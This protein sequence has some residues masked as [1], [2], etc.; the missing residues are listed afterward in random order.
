MLDELIRSALSANS[1]G[2]ALAIA[3]TY[4][5]IKEN[6]SREIKYIS[7]IDNL[8]ENLVKKVDNVGRKVDK[9]IERMDK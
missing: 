7:I 2:L 1:L 6:K 3:M 9:I 8:S 5:T 4:Y